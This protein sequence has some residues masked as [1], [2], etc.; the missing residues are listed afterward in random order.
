MHKTAALGLALAWLL[1]VNAPA[2]SAERAADLPKDADISMRAATGTAEGAGSTATA[3]G[4]A[5]NPGAAIAATTEPVGEAL[6]PVSS[7]TEEAEPTVAYRLEE[8]DALRATVSF[9]DGAV[10]AGDEQVGVKRGDTY[11]FNLNFVSAAFDFRAEAFGADGSL[12]VE[13]A[14]GYGFTV[15]VHPVSTLYWGGRAVRTVG[16]PFSLHMDEAQQ[17][18]IAQPN[19]E[20]LF[21]LRLERGDTQEEAELVFPQYASEFVD[22]PETVDG[23]TLR[24]NAQVRT[25]GAHSGPLLRLYQP[26]ATENKEGASSF[27]L[28]R[29]GAD[30]PYKAAATIPLLP[31]P[32][33]VWALL[34]VNQRIVAASE[35][36]VTAR[37]EHFPLTVRPSAPTMMSFS[38]IEL[39]EPIVGYEVSKDEGVPLKG[40]VR[41]AIGDELTASVEKLQNGVFVRAAKETI[42]LTDETFERFIRWP[43]GPGLYRI[44]VLS[45]LTGQRGQSG[46]AEIARFY[47]EYRKPTAQPD[48]NGATSPSDSDSASPVDTETAQ[49]V[50]IEQ[51]RALQIVAELGIIPDGYQVKE[52]QIEQ[53]LAYFV[54][55]RRQIDPF[56]HG[57]ARWVIRYASPDG[58]GAEWRVELDASTGKLFSFYREDPLR[59]PMYSPAVSYEEAKAIAEAF[60]ARV[61]GDIVEQLRYDDSRESIYTDPLSFSMSSA[62]WISYQRLAGGIP[63][64]Q[65]N[66]HVSIDENGTIF[67]YNY[68]WND[69]VRF[70]DPASAMDPQ[71]AEQAFRDRVAPAYL[72]PLDRPENAR[73]IYEFFPNDRLEAATGRFLDINLS[74]LP[75]VRRKPVGGKPLSEP[76]A[77]PVEPLTKEE[78]AAIAKTV[79]N[80]PAD[81]ELREVHLIGNLW[82]LNFKPGGPDSTESALVNLHRLT[83]LSVNY[84][85]YRPSAGQ[86]PILS[87][88]QARETAER[89]LTAVMPYALDELYPLDYDSSITATTG[90]FGQAGPLLYSYR[91]IRQGVTLGEVR[92]SVHPSNGEV[93]EFV[94]SVHGM[95]PPPP[96]RFPG[97]LPPEQAQAALFDRYRLE[98]IYDS[99]NETRSFSGDYG[100]V[101]AK[102]KDTD[103]SHAVARLI[104]RW[105]PQSHYDNAA[106]DAQTGAWIDRRFGETIQDP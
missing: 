105:I 38:E 66:V 13:N 72:M 46:T 88:H 106:F 76:P 19:M 44:R 53:R 11:F 39:D 48:N 33:R 50:A 43:G 70:E 5:T 14:V 87:W 30:Y 47:A 3:A 90:A 81:S 79:L 75:D 64:P 69:S 102:V 58:T 1:A 23:D 27:E 51:E 101:L 94:N 25:S 35:R 68:N 45:D 17:P 74:P 92:V 84:H 80:L 103:P 97:L 77:A 2:G 71:Q 8:Q 86:R 56:H 21:G 98:L 83:G 18:Y 60:V 55:K 15:S 49:P 9:R 54:V 65:N 42:P 36:D 93:V 26:D 20:A 59:G 10:F 78:A 24:I 41:K 61:N 82:Q 96:A 57:P 89:F 95:A 28:V 63:Y 99:P 16:L 6:R 91:Q 4:V 32:N 52:A 7:R 62:Y 100:D 29:W 85:H 12:K 40:K 34:Q 22:F 37:F 73:P 104:Y 67:S 31:G